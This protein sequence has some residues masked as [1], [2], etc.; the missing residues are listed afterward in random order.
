MKRAACVIYTS[1][2]LNSA[3]LPGVATSTLIDDTAF[4]SSTGEVG[5]MQNSAKEGGDYANVA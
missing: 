4:C 3:H 1:A 5:T 2:I